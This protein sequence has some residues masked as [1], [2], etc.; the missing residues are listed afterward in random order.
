MMSVTVGP[1]VN[2]IYPPLPFG[3]SELKKNNSAGGGRIKRG[4]QEIKRLTDKLLVQHS[5][6]QPTVTGEH[7]IVA[8]R[9]DQIVVVE[10]FMMISFQS[11]PGFYYDE[12]EWVQKKQ[13]ATDP[14]V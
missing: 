7:A 10:R 5:E 4:W 14:Q 8:V 11:N 3:N 12:F 9:S 6:Q 13:G 1:V 2:N